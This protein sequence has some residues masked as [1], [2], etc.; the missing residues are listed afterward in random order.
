MNT[1]SIWLARKV[2]DHKCVSTLY[3]GMLK[4][5][6]CV[7]SLFYIKV[8][9]GAQDKYY[10]GPFETPENLTP[11]SGVEVDIFSGS[12]ELQITNRGC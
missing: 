1:K 3:H 4:K 6:N 7:Y 2:K 12:G 5:S 11:E 10:L 9:I 8:F